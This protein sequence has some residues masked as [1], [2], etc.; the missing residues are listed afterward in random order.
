MWTGTAAFAAWQSFLTARYVSPDYRYTWTAYALAAGAWTLGMLVWSWQEL[1]LGNYSPFPS[2][3]EIGF[4]AYPVLFA[5]GFLLLP[6]RHQPLFAALWKAATLIVFISAIGFVSTI[7]LYSDLIPTDGTGL[8][9]AVAYPV[10]H[11]VAFIYVVF[12]TLMRSGAPDIRL[13]ILL[14][15]ALFCLLFVNSGYA[16]LLNIEASEKL[17]LFNCLWIIGFGFH[18]WAAAERRNLPPEGTGGVE[19]ARPNLALSLEALL[20]AL[21]GGVAILVLFFARRDMVVEAGPYLALFAFAFILGA[22][23]QHFALLRSEHQR[24]RS[25]HAANAAISESETRFRDLAELTAD[26]FW[27]TDM[28]QRFTYLSEPNFYQGAGQEQADWLGKSRREMHPTLTDSRFAE[29]IQTYMDRGEPFYDIR[30]RFMHA[31]RGESWLSVSG[32]PVYDAA[33]EIT[34]YRGIGRNVTAQESAKRKIREQ[35]EL[36]RLVIDNVPATIY[37]KDLEGRYLLV[38]QRLRGYLGLSDEEIEGR[39]SY[40][41]FKSEQSKEYEAQDNEVIASREVRDFH[42]IAPWPEGDHYLHIIKFPVFDSEGNFIAIGGINMDVTAQRNLERQLQQSQKLEAIGQLTGGLA[43]DFNNLLAVILGNAELLSEGLDAKP[44][45]RHLSTMIEAAAERGSELT[46]R[47]LAFS[48]QQGLEPKTFCCNAL[49][50]GFQQLLERT[51]G[52]NIEIEIRGSEDLWLTYADPNQLENALLNLAIN[53]RDAMPDGG[54]LTIETANVEIDADYASSDSELQPGAYVSITFTDSGD[55]M[56]PE[57]LAQA[58]DPFY[59]TKEVGK[60]S[61]LGLSMVYGFLRQSGGFAKLYSELGLGT[62]VRLYFPAASGSPRS[63]PV[64]ERE[65]GKLPRGSETVLVVED[66]EMVRSYVTAQFRELGYHVAE[67]VDGPSALRFLDSDAPADLLFTDMVMPGGLHGYDIAAEALK[68]RPGIKV[69]F[70]TGFNDM[71]RFQLPME[72]VDSPVLRK[73]YRR[74]ELA[75]VLRRVLDQG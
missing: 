14:S 75:E 55:G 74:A 9:I 40:E 43:H 16:L 19:P 63:S 53:A 26:W 25:S 68:K 4:L 45:L 71:T 51:L 60:G 23:L 1:V 24:A 59:T 3:A 20:P 38:N 41:L 57:V 67:A 8:W 17:S 28:A 37:L 32:L 7:V 36:L 31:E 70:T 66:N 46:H 27:E 73:P 11:G 42:S 54:K 44:E 61:G 52:E 5:G 39:R 22:S 65:Q 58:F 2:L 18:A 6:T 47:L 33:G 56:A 64:A 10:A 49:I 69:I 34:G 30:R 29:E 21:C 35:Q 62:T 15:I 50:D 12:L 72:F 13:Y 48:R